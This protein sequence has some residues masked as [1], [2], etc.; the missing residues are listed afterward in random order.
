MSTN[1][2]RRAARARK[3][4]YNQAYGKQGVVFQKLLPPEGAPRFVKA[5]KGLGT[6]VLGTKGL[7]TKVL[8]TKALGTKALGTKALGTKA[9]GF[10]KLLRAWAFP[11]GA[12]V[13]EK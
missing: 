5:C 8:G 6:K 11:L 1:C 2:P 12:K 10:Y 13:V 7:G 9:S 3:S 4:L